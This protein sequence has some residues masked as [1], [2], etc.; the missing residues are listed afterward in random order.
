MYLRSLLTLIPVYR[1]T[2]L[3]LWPHRNHVDIV[4]GA[5]A[6]AVACKKIQRSWTRTTGVDMA[7]E[8]ALAHARPEDC[9]DIISTVCDGARTWGDPELWLRAVSVCDA[10]RAIS[11]L[12]PRNA[13]CAV[14]SFGLDKIRDWYFFLVGISLD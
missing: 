5:R 8:C 6:L 2:A 13:L 1:K 12:E 10:E 9:A 4:F 14:S 3:V 7:V 11:N